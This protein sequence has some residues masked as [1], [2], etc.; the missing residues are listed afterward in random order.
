MAGGR[1]VGWGDPGGVKVAGVRWQG[2]RVG[3]PGRRW[4]GGV[5]SSGWC[6]MA[7]WQSRVAREEVVGSVVVRHDVLK[8]I[9][10]C[11]ATSQH[12]LQC[13]AHHCL[14]P[15]GIILRPT[16]SRP[17]PSRL[18]FSRYGPLPVYPGHDDGINLLCDLLWGQHSGQ[19]QFS[20]EGVHTHHHAPPQQIPTAPE[21]CQALWQAVLQCVQVTG[22]HAAQCHQ[23][24][25]EHLQEALP[26]HLLLTHVQCH[27]AQRH[28]DTLLC[29][30]GQ[31]RLRQHSQLPLHP[32]VGHVWCHRAWASTG[33][34]GQAVV[35]LCAS[36]GGYATPGRGDGSSGEREGVVPGVAV[37]LELQDMCGLHQA[38]YIQHH[39]QAGATSPPHGV[40]QQ[41]QVTL[42][43][44]G[45][46]AQLLHC[47]HIL[48]QHK[49]WVHRAHQHMSV[50]QGQLCQI[51][52]VGWAQQG[53]GEVCEGQGGGQGQ[54]GLA[55]VKVQAEDA[56][57]WLG[58]DHGVGQVLE[59]GALANT[60]P[61]TYHHAR[62]CV[63]VWCRQSFSDSS[64]T[65]Q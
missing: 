17:A 36:A 47:T 14:G 5:V 30:H 28:C 24:G 50:V 4:Q 12:L 22:I 53:L 57:V 45:C 19:V 6:E 61:A 18:S 58:S 26:G 3:W 20:G 32:G 15:L 11:P 60:L 64:N 34:Q 46:S 49:L 33:Q 62:H 40:D 56:G 54:L 13:P 8:P 29:L 39:L 42:H 16:L 35:H 44:T 65:W 43:A 31:R 37:V 55:R 21:W 9:M 38:H 25:I 59:E 1:V 63:G 2:G 7:G 51:V 10:Q 48:L 27:P 23:L 52:G 41:W